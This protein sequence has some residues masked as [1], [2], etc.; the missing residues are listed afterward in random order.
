[1][2]LISLTRGLFAKVDDEDYDYLNQWK[3]S[4]NY[5]KNANT[6]YATRSIILRNNKRTII[7]MHRLIMNAMSG[8]LVDHQDH[9]GI[10]NQKNNLR[11]SNYNQNNSNR[12][13]SKKSS[14]KFLGVHW[15]KN[16]NK[17]CAKIQ[18]NKK[19]IHIGYFHLEIDAA[20]AYN[21]M[22]IQYHGKFANIN[23]FEKFEE[24]RRKNKKTTNPKPTKN[25]K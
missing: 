2:K 16:S 8:I 1:M 23:K 14:S 3:W 7:L 19:G 9:I 18:V 4:A 13:S 24:R 21:E 6:Y 15:F 17:W 5:N 22:A 12:K 25:P 10:N 20:K 11:L